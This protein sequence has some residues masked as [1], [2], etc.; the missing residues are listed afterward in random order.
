[1]LYIPLLACMTTNDQAGFLFT[2]PVW[3]VKPASRN[4]GNGIQVFG[5]FQDI[6]THLRNAK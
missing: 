5:S 6:E 3:I 4:R 1:M 2:G